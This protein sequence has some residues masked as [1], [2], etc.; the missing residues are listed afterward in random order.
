MVEIT[1]TIRTG[2]PR[3]PVWRW[4]TEYFF[5]VF[6]RY[7]KIPPFSAAKATRLRRR[8]RAAERD[9]ASLMI[10]PAVLDVVGRKP[11]RSKR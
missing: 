10:A 1:P 8:W 7:A 3:S 5:G 4:I 6:D 11:R 2:G 9:P